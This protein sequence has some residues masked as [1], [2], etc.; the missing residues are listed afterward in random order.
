[1]RLFIN[2]NLQLI[3][4]RFQVKADYWSNFSINRGVPHFNA[5]AGGDFLRIS[6]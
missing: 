4:H 2:N 6:G 5:H 3:L 1:M